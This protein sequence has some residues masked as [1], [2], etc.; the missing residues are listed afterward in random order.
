VDPGK[1]VGILE[2]G[3]TLDYSGNRNPDYPARDLKDAI[4]PMSELGGMPQ[5][6]DH[7]HNKHN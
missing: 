3:K 1:G 7:A 2:K 6:S 4:L 5:N